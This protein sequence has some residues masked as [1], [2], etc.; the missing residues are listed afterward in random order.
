MNKDSHKEL[1]ILI[2]TDIYL[3]K[4]TEPI[5]IFTLNKLKSI[6]TI[7]EIRTRLS[8]FHKGNLKTNDLDDTLDAIEKQS[9]IKMYI[10]K[11]FKRSV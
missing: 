2:I 11:I 3:K 4:K 1:G 6:G 9:I 8:D 7:Q 10:I 5:A